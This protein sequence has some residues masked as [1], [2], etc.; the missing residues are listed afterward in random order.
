MSAVSA[1]WNKGEAWNRW[2][3]C[4]SSCV[5]GC[6]R[7]WFP[8]PDLGKN[9]AR[10]IQGTS[11]THGQES[12]HLHII[13]ELSI[14]TALV[15]LWRLTK[16]A[17]KILN[18]DSGL[19]WAPYLL[20][21]KAYCRIHVQKLSTHTQRQIGSGTARSPCTVL[22]PHSNSHS[23]D[24]WYMIWCWNYDAIGYQC[25][26][27]WLDFHRQFHT[28]CAEKCSTWE[29]GYVVCFSLRSYNKSAG[30]G[31]CQR[32]SL[33]GDTNKVGFTSEKEVGLLCKETHGRLKNAA[34]YR[35]PPLCWS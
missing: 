12:S 8:Y 4:R 26:V 17:L 29:F 10:R 1:Q 24:P 11:Q 13:G 9:Q 31:K 7:I 16:V 19:L 32:A 2:R 22:F 34:S 28:Q 14:G 33:S 21:L 30:T 6:W 20:P 18:Q 23:Y 25:F 3:E 27:L 35:S 5:Q 15:T